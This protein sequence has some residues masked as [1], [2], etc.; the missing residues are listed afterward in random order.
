VHGVLGAA[1]VDDV[2][3]HSDAPG[4]HA[5]ESHQIVP[6]F[7]DRASDAVQDLLAC[8][9]SAVAEVL[10]S[11]ALHRLLHLLRYAGNRLNLQGC[12]DCDAA[13]SAEAIRGAMARYAV[14]LKLNEKL[15]Q[16]LDTKT[17]HEHGSKLIHFLV[18]MCAS[19]CSAAY[20]PLIRLVA[21][22]NVNNSAM[23]S[24]RMCHACASR[25]RVCIVY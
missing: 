18:A 16:V 23:S 20:W 2:A 1:I 13:H 6:T 22:T 5:Q 25:Q 9:E 24:S 10:G 17:Y 11:T 7:V 8:L 19:N 15:L 21:R 14:S 12:L 4:A 3:R